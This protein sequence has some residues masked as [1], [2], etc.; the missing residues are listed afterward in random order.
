MSRN[1]FISARLTGT[2]VVLLLTAILL[3]VQAGI[4]VAAGDEEGTQQQKPAIAFAASVVGDKNRT[5][6]FVDFD[7][8]I[9]HKV[10]YLENPN[11]VVIDL[12]ETVFNFGGEYQDR[13]RG[14]VSDIRQGAI[15]PGRSRIVLMTNSPTKIEKSVVSPLGDDGRHRLII[16]LM[17]TDYE[18]Y[19]EAVFLHTGQF[20]N[21]GNVAYKGDRI[22]RGKRIN[23]SRFVVVI[24]PGHGGIDGGAEGN[25][26]SLEKSVTLEFSLA[27]KSELERDKRVHVISTRDSDVFVSLDE[28]VA[29]AR[30]NEAD[31]MIS[32]HADSL[33]QRHIRGATI[34]TLSAEGSD[35]L[36]RMIA[37]KE[38]R[39]DLFAGLVLPETSNEVTDILIDLTRRET[40]LF[41]GQFAD[42]LA[43][44]LKGRIRLIKNPVRAANFHVLRAHGIPSVLLELG[45]M[46]N[47]ED[48]HQMKDRQWQERAAKPV[49]T[50]IV[51]FLLTHV[52]RR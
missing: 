15:A 29:I 39:A 10:L 21:S 46:S 49:K 38:N 18:S 41:S 9:T 5:R 25:G 4:A 19:R 42:A 7:R 51:R 35:E 36:S 32:V 13:I 47:A 45:Y 16:D 34:Y 24:D 52:A 23:G 22:S 20:G 26:G 12:P 43:G 3:A 33:R 31:L 44:Q 2:T 6:L 1:H 50:A 30:R 14:L 17:K 37:E 28:R 8:K 40:K 27:L 11:R 48:E